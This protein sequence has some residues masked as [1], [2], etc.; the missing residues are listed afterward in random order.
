MRGRRA[1]LD[2]LPHQLYSIFTKAVESLYRVEQLA[3]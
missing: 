2:C 1:H 3:G